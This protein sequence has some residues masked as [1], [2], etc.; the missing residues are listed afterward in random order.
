MVLAILGDPGAVRRVGKKGVTKVFKYGQKSPWVPSL[1]ELFPKIQADSGSWLG[2]KKW[3]VLLYPIG[4]EFLLSSFREFVHDGY[5]PVRSL[6]LCVQW[7]LLFPTFL[8]RNE[9]TTDELIKRL[10]YYQQK[11]FNL[12]LEYSVFDGSQCI[13]NNRKFKTRRRRESQISNSFTRQNKNFARASRFFAHF[14]AVN[15][16]T[17]QCLISCFVKDVNKQWQNSFSSW[18]WIWLIE[19][20]LQKSSLAFDKVSELE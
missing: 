2:T 5:C 13:I 17:T 1:T 15:C 18:T 3:F 11:Q 20:H 8:T 7:K 10:G 6:S 4:E 14:F 16:T 19:I 9:G 12:P